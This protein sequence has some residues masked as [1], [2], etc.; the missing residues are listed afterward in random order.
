MNKEQYKKFSKEQL[1]KARNVDLGEM[2]LRLWPDTYY[3]DEHGYVRSHQK[4][5]MK[6]DRKRNKFFMNEECDCAIGNTIEFFST[7]MNYGFVKAT[8]FILSY[9]YCGTN[10]VPDSE[11]PVNGTG[12]M[13][14]EEFAYYS[15][16]AEDYVEYED[17]Y[18]EC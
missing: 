10:T 3:E 5:K 12:S 6:I 2:L 4:R 14:D 7:I 16:I 17:M 13:T 18:D 8:E 15:K 9:T 11:L 1:D